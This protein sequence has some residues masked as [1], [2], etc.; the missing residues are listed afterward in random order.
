MNVLILHDE[1]PPDARPDELD[2]FTQV[3][4]IGAALEALGHRWSAAGV[5]LDLAA[6]QRRLGEP[7]TCDVVINLVESLA[8]RM[9][10]AHC[11]PALLDALG[12]PYTGAPTEGLFLT[13]GKTTAKRHLA[14]CGIATPPWVEEGGETDPHAAFLP[15]RYIIKSVWEHASLGL[16]DDAIVEASSADDLRPVIRSRRERLGGEAFAEAFIDGREF[17]LALLESAPEPAAP[18][19]A[20]VTHGRAPAEVFPP[21]E[22]TFVDYAPDKPKIVGYAAKWA[23]ESFEYNRTPRRFAFPPEDAPL[24]G[25]LRELALQCWDVFRL[26]GYVRVD[27]RVDEHGAPWVLEINAN[28]CLSPDA[29]YMAAAAEAGLTYRDVVER[30]LRAAVAR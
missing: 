18:R 19:G 13:C 29:G 21:A 16:D 14:R 23:E 24:V 4:A 1:L 10:L 26:R 12:V 22:I 25:R 17:N 27:F 11:V 28:P 30:L 15:G 8:R 6:L 5:T 7:P 9:R 3:R 2:V 20:A